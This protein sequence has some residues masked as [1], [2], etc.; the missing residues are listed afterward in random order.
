MNREP[1]AIV[2]MCVI[3]VAVLL[4]VRSVDSREVDSGE[5]NPQELSDAGLQSD[6]PRTVVTQWIDFVLADNFRDSWTLTT[7]SDSLNAHHDLPRLR[8]KNGIRVER[9]LGNES[10][11]V[12]VTNTV[13]HLNS[14]RDRA[15][16]FWLARRDGDWLI[17][18]FYI[19]DP[20][21]IEEQLRGFLLGGDA[22]WRVTRDDLVGTWLA[23]PGNPGGVGSIA[24]G[25]RFH[26]DDDGSF[27]L[28]AWGP[29]GP[30]GGIEV[31]RGTW[32]FECDRIIREQDRQRLIS[33]ISWVGADSMNLQPADREL[34]DGR[35]GTHYKREKVAK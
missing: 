11:A 22:Q 24:C 12:V 29:A 5:S 25:S 16:A 31:K 2:A 30:D 9:S 7:K 33:R 6:G 34:G 3:G 13:K 4:T 28:E 26:L 23:G 15:F 14:G 10:V 18:R 21:N 8:N 32:R 27:T 19:D 20:Q 17:D 1:A 35:F